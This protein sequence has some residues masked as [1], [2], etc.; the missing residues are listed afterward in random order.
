MSC[1]FFI[2]SMLPYFLQLYLLE[3]LRFINIWYRNKKCIICW[4]ESMIRQELGNRILHNVGDIILH[5]RWWLTC[6]EWN[7]SNSWQSITRARQF[8]YAS[9]VRLEITRIRN[10]KD[11]ITRII[12][13]LKLRLSVRVAKIKTRD[14]RLKQTSI[15]NTRQRKKSDKVSPWFAAEKYSVSSINRTYLET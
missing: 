12:C 2:H 1:Q 5:S 14:D 8:I 9:I 3:G 7:S 10:I 11:N 13:K 4:R 6:L 15:T